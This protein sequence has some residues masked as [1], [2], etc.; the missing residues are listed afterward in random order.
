MQID[1]L[2]QIIYIL[3]EQK[4]VTAKMLS[5]RFEVSKRTIYRDIDT[6]SQCGIPLYSTRGRN[7]GITILDNFVL[8][9][10]AMTEQEQ[11]HIL[12]AL[13]SLPRG[14]NENIK[15]TLKK[16]SNFF[17]KSYQNYIQ[18]DFSEW[19]KQKEILFDTLKKAIFDKRVISF[20]YYNSEGEKTKRKVEPYQL[21]FKSKNWYLKAYCQ[22]KKHLRIFKLNRIK[23]LV[24][25][26]EFFDTI[27][28][29]QES[30]IDNEAYE[31]ITIVLEIDSSMAYRVYD[32]F[33]IEQICK[34]QNGDFSVILYCAENNWIYDYILSWGEYA[35]VKEPLFVKE[36][37]AQKIKNMIKTYNI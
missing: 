8:N 28:E 9:K 3:L 17:Q 27:W 16:Y 37:I 25:T 21:W 29:V 23:N 19:G 35:V 22:E 26:E 6:L 7:G 31:G 1:R 4:N 2:F 13:Q 24:L 11:Y 15:E 34:K 33:E 32:E 5:E 12:M 30:E 36:K 14:G 10:S 18:V 20:I